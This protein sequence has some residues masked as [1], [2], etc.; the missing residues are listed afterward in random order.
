[1]AATV[2]LGCIS[3]NVRAPHWRGACPAGIP[4]RAGDTIVES[5]QKCTLGYVYRSGPAYTMGLTA[6]HCQAD[7]NAVITDL[8]AG[9]VEGTSLGI[10]PVISKG[11]DWQLISFGDVPWSAEYPHHPLLDLR[12]VPWRPEGRK[13]AITGGFNDC[14]RHDIGL[15]IWFLGPCECDRTA[16]GF[17]WPVLRIERNR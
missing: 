5:G 2:R 16:W 6:G 17:R 14:V 3:G 9:G 8:D 7:A 15:V 11:Q 1:M 4:A 13:S 12:R 10:S